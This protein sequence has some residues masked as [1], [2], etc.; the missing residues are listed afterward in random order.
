[1]QIDIN[2]IKMM[3]H[4][5]LLELPEKKKESGLIL[6]EKTKQEIMKVE[7]VLFKVLR[8]PKDNEDFKYSEFIAEGDHVQLCSMHALTLVKSGGEDYLMAGLNDIAFVV[9][10]EAFLTE[11][12]SNILAEA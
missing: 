1:M 9:P 11:P 12:Q 3:N 8:I 7:N 4:Q 6:S 5:I 2:K 10:K